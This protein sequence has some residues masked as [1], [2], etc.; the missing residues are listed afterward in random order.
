MNLVNIKLHGHL[1]EKIGS[2]WNL[3]V[4]SIR[5]ALHAINTLTKGKLNRY[6]AKTEQGHAK[7]R[8]LINEENVKHSV[9][10]ID[11]SNKEEVSKTELYT[12]RSDLRSIDIVPV[13]EGSELNQILGAVLLVIGIVLMFIPGLQPVGFMLALAGIGMLLSKPPEKEDFRD[14]QGAGETSYY[15]SG[16]QNIVG[17]GGPVPLGYGECVVGSQTISVKN[18]IVMRD[19]M[20]KVITLL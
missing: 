10:I 6:L 12:E 3:A 2:E 4:S 13:I 9:P 7:Y 8:F 18:G 14:I 5:E 17:E 19:Y 11:E 16:G 20:G 1:G 15:F